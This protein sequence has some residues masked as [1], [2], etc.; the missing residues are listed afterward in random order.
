MTVKELIGILE[1]FKSDLPV[2]SPRYYGMRNQHYLVEVN[3]VGP[4][5]VK[6]ND[7]G[8]Y[9]PVTEDGEL[10]VFLGA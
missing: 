5:F 10:A 7:L 8:H 9:D 6:K 4:V 2:V 3:S 1:Q